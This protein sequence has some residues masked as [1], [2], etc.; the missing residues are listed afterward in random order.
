MRKIRS[1]ILLLT[2]V[3]F[4]YPAPVSAIT[5][6]R[7][8]NTS[9]GKVIVGL[10]GEKAYQKF[11]A[12]VSKGGGL[13]YYAG[14][15]AF[16]V[17]VSEAS[18]VLLYP[19]FY[20][21]FTGTLLEFK[22]FL[23]SPDS[24]LREITK[25]VQVVFDSPGCV[26]VADNGAIIPKKTGRYS[27]LVIY[28]GLMSN[29]LYLQI[30]EPKEVMQE[31]KAE[32]LAIDILPYRPVVPP[33]GAVHFVAL[34]T[35]F[36]KVLNVYSVKDISQE[37]TW[38]MRQP[39]APV[40]NKEDNYRLYFLKKGQAEVLAK[41][42]EKNSFLARVEVKQR[43]DS[44]I[45]RL[46]HILVLPEVTMLGPKEDTGMRA[47]GTYDDNSVVEL[48][49][50]VKWKIT[51]PDILVYSSSGHFIAKTEGITEV[52]ATKDGV[53]G[54]PAKVVVGYK[55]LGTKVDRKAADPVS[56]EDNN[57]PQRK[58]LE[59]IK[60][61]VE[62]LKKDFLVKKKEL[63]E[64]QI[65]PKSLEISLGEGGKLSAS[66]LYSDGSASDLT[67]LGNWVILDQAVATVAS[68][69]ITGVSVGQTHAYV[70]FKGVRSE[71][72][73]LIVGGPRLVALE[74][75]P[76]SLKIP[77]DGKAS[78]KVQ[79]NYF[80]HSQRDLTGLVSWASQGP[81]VVK[82]EKGV[83]RPLKFGQSKVYAEYSR[84]KSNTVG[85][86]VIVTL[87]WLLR[88]LA[89][90]IL[91]LLLGIFCLAGI[92]YLLARHKRRQLRLLKDKPR[93]FIL[94]LHEN[95]ISLVTIFGLRYDAY[96]FPLFYAEQAKQKFMVENNVFLNFSVKFEEAKYSR[97]LLQDSD[98]LA[99]LNDYNAF[100]QSLCNNQSRMLSFYRYCLALFHC[101]PVFIFPA[102]GQISGK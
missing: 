100:F 55:S 62:Q 6:Y 15:P 58:T 37:A 10:D 94:G 52:T 8:V 31:E 64:I 22:A 73:N 83:A 4:L 66:G 75:T 57:V 39:P 20:Q 56:S 80:D 71:Y 46:K 7:E 90:I 16:F 25:E 76:P 77:R 28:Q 74:L 70:E 98:A 69:N 17:N 44:G 81:A 101:R 27:A 13:W 91:A 34:G 85:I 2:A 89:K 49:Q 45:K 29:P 48:T 65:T 95:A 33:E 88:L 21:A 102:S 36:D 41:Y 14:P 32:L 26:R 67:I 11:G 97:H 68:G 84:L 5:R 53:E 47:F 72:A 92:L 38:F 19:N 86:D 93:E 78:L 42:K 79:G 30:N 18:E 63:K 59:E 50:D 12:P 51:D 35:F 43:M 40:W 24:G 99:A 23:R 9:L 1:A 82:I 60:D 3:I 87:G 96:T 61:S 54:L